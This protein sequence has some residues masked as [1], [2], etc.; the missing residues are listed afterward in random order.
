MQEWQIAP[1]SIL[2]IVESG[3][4]NDIRRAIENHRGQGCG[5]LTAISGGTPNNT[6][7][8]GINNGSVVWN[9]TTYTGLNLGPANTSAQKAAALTTLLGVPTEARPP[10]ISF[11][12]GRYVAIFPWMPNESPTFA[13]GTVVDAFGL[14][15]DRGRL[16]SRPFH[17]PAR[18]RLDSHGGCDPAY[19]LPG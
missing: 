4:D 19:W 13:T 2:A 6:T 15:P 16:S 3:S 14:D 12:D 7:L 17:P 1:N 5:T 11:I 10:T 18:A 9:G 8:D